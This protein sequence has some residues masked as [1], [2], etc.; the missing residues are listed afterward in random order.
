MISRTDPMIRPS[1]CTVAVVPDIMVAHELN[2]VATQAAIAA[3]INVF[4]FIVLIL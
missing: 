1:I 3:I 2:S 4:F